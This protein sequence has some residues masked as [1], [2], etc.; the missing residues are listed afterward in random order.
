MIWR[1][2]EMA[3]PI[4]TDSTRPVTGGVDTHKDTHVAAVIDHLG[5]ELATRS[6]PTTSTGYQQLL[7]WMG[8]FGIIERVGI[9]GTGSWGAA[10]TRHLNAANI[11]VTEINRTNRQHRR[12]HGKTDPADAIAAARA[13]L[14]GL[15]AGIPKTG[16]GPVE[17][18]R[19]LRIA[20]RSAIQTRTRTMNQIR[21][22]IDTAP[23]DVRDRY[24][25]LTATK[26]IHTLARTRPDEINIAATDVAATFALR[27]L[28]RRWRFLTDQI[29]ELDTHL[30][31]LVTGTAPNLL[32]VHC[33]G[34]DTAAALLIAAGD[35]PQR[36]GTQA[37]FAAL[38]GVNPVP[39]SSGKTIR[40]RLN[41][42]GN[43]DANSALFHIVLARMSHDQRTRDYVQRRTGEGRTKREIIRILKR[44]VA[45]ALY[46]VLVNDLNNLAT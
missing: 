45:R 30:E 12:R 42:A 10:L 35:N 39:A 31:K 18:I 43:R 37:A 41:R 16:D 22:V 23:A 24:R 33:V 19:M 36:L 11:D 20:R 38:C 25:H 34:I 26:L 13:C 40:Y 32:A 44:Y 3:I 46:P 6:F 15:D 1:K 5:R 9:E 8:T 14:A 2:P 28:A 7:D 4:L 17:S 21:A 27:N 29:N